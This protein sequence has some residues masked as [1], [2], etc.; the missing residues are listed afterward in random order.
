MSMW[1]PFSESARRSVVL[2]HEVAQKHA[3][4]NIDT[5]HLLLGIIALP[6]NLAVKVLASL[7]IDVTKCRQKVEAMIEVGDTPLEGEMI[8]TPG[9]KRVIE[10]SFEEA[11][12][13]NHHYI[14]TEHLLLGLIREEKGIAARVLAELGADL[15]N[16]REQTALL[17]PAR[18]PPPDFDPKKYDIHLD[19]KF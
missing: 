14:G 13:F 16:V 19:S 8:F 3:S 10:L 5:E 18:T 4:K 1:E 7:D 6:E 9:A 12:R 15:E 17:L 11:R 2:A